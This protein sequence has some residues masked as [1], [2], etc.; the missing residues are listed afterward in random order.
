V[1]NVQQVS[2]RYSGNRRTSRVEHTFVNCPQEVFSRAG[3]CCFSGERGSPE[4]S[5]RF[6]QHVLSLLFDLLLE[7]SK[8]VVEKDSSEPELIPQRGCLKSA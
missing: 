1:K 7:A 5:F 6:Q 4:D 8:E 3:S 2:T